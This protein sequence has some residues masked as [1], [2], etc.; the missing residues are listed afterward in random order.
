MPFSAYLRSAE[1][2][3]KTPSYRSLNIGFRVGFQ[4]ASNGEAR[5]SL[6]TSMG[7]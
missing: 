4:K 2:S 3:S 5:G 6:G 7:V 1:R